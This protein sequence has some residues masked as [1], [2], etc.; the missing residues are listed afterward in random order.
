MRSWVV[1]MIVTALLNDEVV[2][3][4]EDADGGGRVEFAGGFVGEDQG[5][6]VGQGAGDGDALLLAAGE[7]VGAVPS[8]SGES[9]RF[10]QF[11]GA[12]S[13]LA[14]AGSGDAQREFDVLVG[15]EQRQ[16]SEG[17]EDEADA[18]ASELGELALGV[19]GDVLA[20]DRDVPGGG[21]VPD[22]RSG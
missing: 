6:R 14:D 12:A 21:R 9:D 1:V 3:Q 17:L 8:A 2:E 15:R 16:Q 18:V 7:F 11:V 5:G 4:A 13:A 22:L 20:V 10:E 19:L